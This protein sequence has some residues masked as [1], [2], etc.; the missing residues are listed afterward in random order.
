[1][2]MIPSAANLASRETGPAIAGHQLRML[3][4]ARI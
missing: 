3:D 2:T 1:M 4:T